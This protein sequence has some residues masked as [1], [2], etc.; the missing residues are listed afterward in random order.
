MRHGSGSPAVG[1]LSTADEGSLLPVVP[2]P[3]GPRQGCCTAADAADARRVADRLGIP[4]Y[5]IDFHEEFNRI[6]DYFVGEYVAGRTPNPCV[7]CNHVL[8][9]GKLFEYA[10]GIGAEYVAT[11]HYARLEASGAGDRPAGHSIRL[12]RAVD[13]AKDQSYVLFGVDRSLLPRM[14]LPV[15]NHRKSEIRRLAGSLGLAVAEKRDSQEICF[16]SCGRY[17]ELVRHR[18]SEDLSGPIL[19]VAGRV[20]GRHGGIERFTVGQRKGLGVAL[21]KRRFVVRID[22]NSRC[23]VVGAREDLAVTRLEANRANWLSQPPAGPF[24]CSV[25][26]RAHS[27]AMSAVA[28]VI[29]P[30]GLKV[31]FD[32]P[33][34]GVAPGQAVVCYQG[35]LVLGGAWIASTAATPE[36]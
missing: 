3:P 22:R 24:R 35:D 10:D 23:V 7:V 9:F 30:G 5:A 1:P 14:M 21:G 25:Q 11:G 32:E 15:G 36:D 20:L 18:S 33:C 34:H 8:K 12:R 13:H 6:I 26:Y 4:F 29:S 17:D 31:V 28:E 19:D 16:V 27:P 2:S